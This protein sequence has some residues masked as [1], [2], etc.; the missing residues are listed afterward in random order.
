MLSEGEAPL[1]AYLFSENTQ[2]HD[3][4][5]AATKQR[6]QEDSLSC[7]GPDVESTQPLTARLFGIEF[8]SCP[9]NESVGEIHVFPG[10]WVAIDIRTNLKSME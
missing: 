7:D 6:L 1:R 5:I 10:A 4:P 8:W 2:N 9:G 3:L